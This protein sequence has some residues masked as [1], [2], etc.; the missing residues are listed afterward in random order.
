MCA[1]LYGVGT[2]LVLL[3][4][5]GI[6][7]H[8]FDRKSLECIWDRMATFAYTVVFSVTLVWIPIIIIGFSYLNIYIAVRRSDRRVSRAITIQ[9]KGKRSTSLAKTLFIIYAVFATCWIPY[10]LIIVVDR[11]NSFSHIAH[12]Y[13]TMFAHL[14]PSINWL[15]YYATNKK[16]KKAFDRIA[17]LNKCFCRCVQGQREESGSSS[18][19][20]STSGTLNTLAKASTES[21]F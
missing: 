16:F 14:H 20:S 15:V 3:N 6:G 4:L 8:S 12:V 10:A 13:V 5:A 7:D 9:K 17:H 18:G 11:H 1:C 21:A 2:T 19:V